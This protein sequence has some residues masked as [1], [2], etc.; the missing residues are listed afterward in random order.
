MG[1]YDALN[2]FYLVLLLVLVGSSLI[3]MRLPLGKVIKMVL[4]WVAI[5]GAGF[6]LFSFRGEFSALGS[7][8]SSEAMG[9]PIAQGGEYRI[10]MAADGHFWVDASINGHQAHFLVDSGATVTTV[11]RDT[12]GK[13]GLETGMRVAMVETANGTVEMKMASA[14]KFEVGPIARSDFT[15]QV[16]DRDSSNVL[17]MNFLSKLRSWRV[18]RNYLVLQP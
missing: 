2:T 8:L 3:G 17:G 7:R 16:N 9:T 15:V 13:A 14:D 1:S 5:F 12:A 4:A 11:S 18:E 10:P 6:I